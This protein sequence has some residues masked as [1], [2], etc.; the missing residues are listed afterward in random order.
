MHCSGWRLGFPTSHE[1]AL[2]CSQLLL[3]NSIGVAGSVWV[4]VL[5]ASE[6]ASAAPVI[7]GWFGNTGSIGVQEHTASAQ[8]QDRAH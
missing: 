5:L 7:F 3:R 6:P 4:N 2:L 8:A 1:R